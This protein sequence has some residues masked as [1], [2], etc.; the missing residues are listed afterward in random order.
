M[1]YLLVYREQW[2]MIYPGTHPTC[3]LTEEWEKLERKERSMIWLCLADLLLLN[4]SGE[5]SSKKLWEKMGSLYQSKSLV[6]KLFLRKK[7]YLLRMS[8][9]SSVIEHLNAFNTVLRQ[10]LSM[11]I[12]ITDEE[13]CINL[14]CSFPES[15]D[16]LVVAIGI[17]TTKIALEYVVSSWFS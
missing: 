2:T 3:M 11:D 14:L 5:D 1:E 12:K 7:V 9:G 17:N 13:K 16:S 6:I 4:V 10:L 15:W 8:D